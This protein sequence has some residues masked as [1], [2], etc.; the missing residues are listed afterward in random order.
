[1][2]DL[3]SN[4]RPAGFPRDRPL[5][6]TPEQ[7][8]RQYEKTLFEYIDKKAEYRRKGY[9]P[10]DSR[11]LNWPNVWSS[12]VPNSFGSQNKNQ[13][14]VDDVNNFERYSKILIKF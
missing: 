8:Y 2:P 9:K 13:S 11:L 4:L 5:G 12:R 14:E 1:M 3:K 6:Q 7:N 10:F